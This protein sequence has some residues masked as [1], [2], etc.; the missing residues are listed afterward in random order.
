MQDLSIEILIRHRSAAE[1]EAAKASAP[2]EIL[3]QGPVPA[4]AVSAA[5]ATPSVEASAGGS[6]AA[7]GV[8]KKRAREEPDDDAVVL[9]DDEEDASGGGIAAKRAHAD[10]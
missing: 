4:V 10:I 7:S 8:T 9:L 5:S 3:G 6:T 2:F 1:F